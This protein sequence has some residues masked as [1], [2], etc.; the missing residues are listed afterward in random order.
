[1][2]RPLRI[3][4]RGSALARWQSEFVAARLHGIESDLDVQIVHISSRG[5]EV[6]T[7]PLWQ[8]EGT[9]FFTASIERALVE[10]EVDVAV[11][12]YK[13]LPV[14]TTPGLIV[15][16]VPP[17]AQVE[18]VLCA[19]N[20]FT[21]STLPAGSRVGTCSARRTA[22]VRALRP[23]LELLPLRGNVPTRL[24]RVAAGDL[25]AV[26][27][28][29]AGLVRLGLDRH[30]TDV[31]ALDLIL[32]APAQGALAI[33][34]R[35]EDTWIA[36][37]LAAL[38]DPETRRAVEAERTLLHALGGGCSVPVGAVAQASGD[39]LVLRAGVFGVEPPRAIRVQQHGAESVALGEAAA[40]QLLQ[41]GAGQIL[42]AFEKT[43]RIDSP[44]ITGGT[45]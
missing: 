9:G 1:M 11:H 40:R 18:D 33:Q 27:L 37:R 2:N 25:D 19:R 45:R 20:G 3:G 21:L 35:E 6:T 31:F 38:D 32:P 26:V 5:D 10:G 17:R 36:E 23:D 8:V 39:E 13:D 41:L 29:R 34:C 30:I 12:S 24:E 7:Q 28:A 43:A 22:Q 14:E 44:L 15:A 16:A 42:E 4:T